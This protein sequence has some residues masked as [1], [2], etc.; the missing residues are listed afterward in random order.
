CVT[1]HQNDYD[2]TND[3]NHLSAGFSTDCTAC[4]TTG[5]WTPSTFDHDSQYFPIY[6]GKHQGEWDQCIDC[7][8]TNNYS[9]FS[10]I[11]CHEHSNKA[12]VDNDH[13][14]ESGYVYESNACYNCHPTG[15][16]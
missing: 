16:D 10:C 12:E 2:T 9:T 8:T 5:G 7:H 1:C 3:P 6:S 14:G 15:Q 4:H 13:K 11:D